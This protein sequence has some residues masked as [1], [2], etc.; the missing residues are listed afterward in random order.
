MN[1]LLVNKHDKL[2]NQKT[3]SAENVLKMFGNCQLNNVPRLATT[4]TRN[5]SRPPLSGSTQTGSA[6][7]STAQGLHHIQHQ[8]R[9]NEVFVGQYVLTS[10][11]YC[12]PNVKVVGDSR[13]CFNC[14][15]KGHGNYFSRNMF[16]A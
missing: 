3:H 16:S 10:L 2:L 12:H 14:L 7:M 9:H 15:Q 8:H 11:Q 13:R 1:V 6:G 4:S 5:T